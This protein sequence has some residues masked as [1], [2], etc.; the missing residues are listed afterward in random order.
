MNYEDE[1]PELFE[2]LPLNWNQFE[3]LRVTLGIRKYNIGNGTDV[4]DDEVIELIT[5][6][7]EGVASEVEI[8]VFKRAGCQRILE[9]GNDEIY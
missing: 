8:K 7:K 3:L 4:T 9:E 5:N 2:F 6:I 1:C